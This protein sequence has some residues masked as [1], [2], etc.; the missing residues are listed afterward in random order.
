MK[1]VTCIKMKRKINFKI[2]EN[3]TQEIQ[4]LQWQKS[5]LCWGSICSQLPEIKEKFSLSGAAI[6]Y[7][8]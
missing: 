3:G 7:M 2:Y 8:N 4:P 6:D 5:L 1:E